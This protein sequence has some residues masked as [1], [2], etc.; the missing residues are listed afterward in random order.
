M[1]L[2]Q[3]R[4]LRRL[5]SW[6]AARLPLALPLWS[7]STPRWRP[8]LSSAAAR[9]SLAASQTEATCAARLGAQ[10]PGQQQGVLRQRRPGRY[11]SQLCTLPAPPAGKPSNRQKLGRRLAPKSQPSR[12]PA[13]RLLACP[14]PPSGH[15]RSPLAA[16]PQASPRPPPPSSP[17][18]WAGGPPPPRRQRGPP[19]L[20]HRRPLA[21]WHARPACVPA[22]QQTRR[23]SQALGPRA[24]RRL[25]QRQ[26]TCAR[27]PAAV[28]AS[29]PAPAPSLPSS[30]APA[31]ARGCRPPPLRP[32]AFR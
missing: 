6:A 25:P 4:T 13:P 21:P 8:S 16:M 3:R 1:R 32:G 30:P 7:R 5:D 14:K 31:A 26:S 17:S 22:L 15:S 24:A 10:P 2:P 27:W 20:R 12:R 23:P 18:C 11:L 28:T 29:S 9:R 19:L